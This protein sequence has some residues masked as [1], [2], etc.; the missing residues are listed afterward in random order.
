MQP[1]YDVE[2]GEGGWKLSL[3]SDAG[4]F[5]GGWFAD[6]P[7]DEFETLKSFCQASKVGSKWIEDQPEDWLEEVIE[8]VDRDLRATQRHN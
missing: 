2:R 3:T 5:D 8:K 7:V 4:R 6:D 1:Y